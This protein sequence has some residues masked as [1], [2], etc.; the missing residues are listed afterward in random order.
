MIAALAVPNLVPTAIATND[1]LTGGAYL[2]FSFKFPLWSR[3]DAA[4]ADQSYY[5][6]VTN[7]GDFYFNSRND[8]S[9]Q[10]RYLDKLSASFGIPVYGKIMLAPRVDFIFYENKVNRNHF[11]A[12][13]PML[14][15]SY[16]FK[17]RQG[18]A[19]GRALGYGAITQPPTTPAH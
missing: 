5:F 18:M 17:R 1:F 8:T 6:L 2:N 4:G 19:T 10:T 9:V 7:K 14:S 16:S 15:L 11:R 12:V 13:A 3:Q